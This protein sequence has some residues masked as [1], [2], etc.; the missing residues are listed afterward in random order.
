M[1]S[2]RQRDVGILTALTALLSRKL[3]DEPELIADLSAQEVETDLVDL[4]ELLGSVSP[5]YFEIDSTSFVLVRDE[6][7]GGL[8]AVEGF[9]LVDL[10]DIMKDAKPC[11]VRVTIGTQAL[12]FDVSALTSAST[13]EGLAGS[14]EG[15]H[16]NLRLAAADAD[17]DAPLGIAFAT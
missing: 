15:A 9:S 4:A 3:Y 10:R 14:R 11:A 12:A 2:E 6:P 13:K 1:S 5:G 16:T 7:S 8:L 17:V